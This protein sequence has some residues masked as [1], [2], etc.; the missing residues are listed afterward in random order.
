MERHAIKQVA[1]RMKLGMRIAVVVLAGLAGLPNLARA[2]KVDLGVGLSTTLAPPPLFTNGALAYPSLDGGAYPGVSA[3]VLFFHHFGVGGEVYWRAT[4]AG[5]YVPA[6]YGPGVG[7]R[8]VFYNVNL[9]SAPRL[10]PHVHLEF[11]AGIGALSTQ[12]RASAGSTAPPSN[13]QLD[14][15]FGGGLKIYVAKH[16]FIRPEGR[17]YVTGNNNNSYAGQITSRVGVALGCT[18]P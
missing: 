18:V 6:T 5:N 8:P 2:Q 10:A 1:R 17:L 11:V 4:P 9:I 14:A 13:N 3:D 15:D 12:F 7:Y 16:I